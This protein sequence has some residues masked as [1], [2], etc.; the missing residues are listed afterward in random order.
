MKNP[1]RYVSHALTDKRKLATVHRISKTPL[2]TPK[3]N[4]HFRKINSYE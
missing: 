1:V 3:K 2:I 4:Q